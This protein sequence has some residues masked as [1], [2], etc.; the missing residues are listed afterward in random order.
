VRTLVDHW[1]GLLGLSGL[2]ILG[3]TTAI[4]GLSWIPGI[5]AII[6]LAVAAAKA[7]AAAL[8]IVAPIFAGLFQ[9]LIWIWQSIIF[10]GVKDILD[11]WVTVVTV[12]S[13]GLM[14]WFGLAVKYEVQ[15]KVD[16]RKLNACL[17]DTNRTT[18][19][20]EIEEPETDIQ[21]PWPF[22]WK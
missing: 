9:G 7:I 14:L 6:G 17:A 19:N 20:K 22:N 13:M 18:R 3:I 5:S 21:L 10:P 16:V 8:E 12:G 1:L 4:S 2:S 11:D 15:H